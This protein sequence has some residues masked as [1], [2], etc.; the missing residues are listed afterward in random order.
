MKLISTKEAARIIGVSQ[1]R[2]QQFVTQ[3]RL[4]AQKIGGVWLVNPDGLD[5]VRNLKNGR[6]K[7]PNQ[8][9]QA[10]QK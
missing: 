1:R 7:N 9:E 3:G 10:C 4:Q 5:K 2:V 8:G 6:P